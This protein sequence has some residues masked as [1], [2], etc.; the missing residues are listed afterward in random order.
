MER[1]SD[2]REAFYA[3]QIAAAETRYASNEVGMVGAAPAKL[4]EI[5][6]PEMQTINNRV[7]AAMDEVSNLVARAGQI[8]DR[9]LGSPPACANAKGEAEKPRG[10]VAL[11]H[12][13]LDRLDTQI[14][15]MRDRIG[16]LE[17]L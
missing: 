14:S 5:A 9:L 6:L 16:R 1:A 7:L 4:G 11:V 15:W 2:Q 12:S 3:N 8:T 13:S 10:D 17:R